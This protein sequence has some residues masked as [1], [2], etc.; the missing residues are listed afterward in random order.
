MA[1][2]NCPAGRRAV[3]EL[4]ALRA[5]AARRGAISAATLRVCFPVLVCAAQDISE[6]MMRCD[7]GGS[8]KITTQT[9][10]AAVDYWY[11]DLRPYDLDHRPHVPTSMWCCCSAPEIPISPAR[12]PGAAYRVA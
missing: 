10:T 6:V 7:P 9:L 3:H 12:S 1:K 11:S 8:R 2:K 5:R 4:D